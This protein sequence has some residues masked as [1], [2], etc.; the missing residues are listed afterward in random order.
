MNPHRKH[1]NAAQA[2]MLTALV[3]VLLVIVATCAQ[4]PQPVAAQ[5][6]AP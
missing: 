4:Q 3:G 2:V 5:E 6:V 1:R